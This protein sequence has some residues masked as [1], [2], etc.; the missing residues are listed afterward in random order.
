[1]SPRLAKDDENTLPFKGRDRVG[2]GF[3]DEGG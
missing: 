3:S 1:M 2:M